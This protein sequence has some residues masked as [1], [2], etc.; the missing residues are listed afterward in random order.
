MS[1]Y[2]D[3]LRTTVKTTLTGINAEEQKRDS[4]LTVAN[5]NLYYAVGN[6]IRAED[7]RDKAND[8][9]NQTWGI[10]HQ[11]VNCSNRANNLLTTATNANDNITATVTNTATAA[12]NVQVAANAVLKIAAGIGS[13]NN[14]VN[15]SGY[16]TDIQR[17]TGYAN[18]VMSKTAYQAELTSQ[19]SM[20][21]S[22]DTAQIIAKQVFDE[23]TKTKTWFDN[24]LA[25][26]D[27]ELKNLTTTR[28]AD[29]DALIA[30]NTDQ[31][32]KEGIVNVENK[33]YKAV[34]GS[35]ASANNT[36]NNNLQVNTNKV[37]LTESSAVVPE[38]ISNETSLFDINL[39][40]EKF[41]PAFP[42]PVAPDSQEDKSSISFLGI[43]E[44]DNEYYIGISKA[45]TAGLFSFDVA[46]T[47]F[48]N[49]SSNRFLKVTPGV[50]QSIAL[51]DRPATIDKDG[52]SVECIEA[53]LKVDVNGKPIEAGTDYVAF[54]YIVLDGKYKKAIN[55]FNDQMSA[56]SQSF[57]LAETLKKVTYQQVSTQAS[58]IQTSKNTQA[59]T[60][61]SNDVSE[62]KFQFKIEEA[63][64]NPDV[65]YRGIMVPVHSL[66]ADDSNSTCDAKFSVSMWF[67]LAIAMQ[68]AEANYQ[69][70]KA[71]TKINSATKK[72]EVVKDTFE[73]SVSKLDPDNFGQRLEEGQQYIS[74]VLSIVP[75]TARN[76]E[77]ESIS[78]NYLPYLSDMKVFCMEKQT[79]SSVEKTHAKEL[80]VA[81]STGE[82]T[83]ESDTAT[84][85]DT[86]QAENSKDS[87]KSDKGKGSNK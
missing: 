28:I 82:V 13:A 30:A 35:Y 24:M 62:Y 31:R 79:T 3:N 43:S 10:N 68:V 49:F 20:Q 51:R 26:T 38:F 59:S 45:D 17:M 14:I 39:Y 48:H 76:A 50:W 58:D 21:A 18:E 72:E 40:F 56:A 70:A 7:K 32:D 71:T 54:I 15:A 85:S 83:G 77:G 2:N 87:A 84:K 80:P 12:T 36:L 60:G 55:N 66:C 5:Y 16:D 67:D 73:F 52:K 22:A 41:V 46:E 33:E 1:T 64:G 23:A 81:S 44:L 61:S 69:V 86:D 53:Q 78:S 47:T 75:P 11:G 63:S 6:Q 25:R 4:S 74:M 29:T 8:N 19:M 9:Y 37:S 65:Q 57:I 34:Q 42:L 27:A